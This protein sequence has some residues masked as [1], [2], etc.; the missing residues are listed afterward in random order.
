MKNKKRVY[1]GSSADMIRLPIL[2]EFSSPKL[3]I[4]AGHGQ[5][6]GCGH[7][8]EVVGIY[9]TS[10]GNFDGKHAV[11]FHTLKKAISQNFALPKDLRDSFGQSHKKVLVVRLSSLGTKGLADAVRNLHFRDQD[12]VWHGPKKKRRRI[13]K[14]RPDGEMSPSHGVYALT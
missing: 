14:Q 3:C 8:V 6:I 5:K 9:I 7:E 13:P 10:K 2:T 1:V 4:L 12:G 11:L